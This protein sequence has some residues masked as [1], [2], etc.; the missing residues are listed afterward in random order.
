MSAYYGDSFKR[1]R[2]IPILLWY[3]NRNDENRT[4]LGL[5]LDF[6]PMIYDRETGNITTFYLSD[7]N[8]T[9]AGSISATEKMI[10][11]S[12][13][14]FAETLHFTKVPLLNWL[15]TLSYAQSVSEEREDLYTTIHNVSYDLFVTDSKIL[16]GM[17]NSQMGDVI[18]EMYSSA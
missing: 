11:F 3:H 18:K 14:L 6:L 4:M 2:K 13:D 1:L 15:D 16:R 8:Y 10:L 12:T 9:S 17:I 7:D 5:C